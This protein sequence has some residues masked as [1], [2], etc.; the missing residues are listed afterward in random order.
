[1]KLR[2]IDSMFIDLSLKRRR[3]KSGNAPVLRI[4]NPFKNRVSKK[5][6]CTFRFSGI[7]LGQ[8][9]QREWIRLGGPSD[10]FVQRLLF[11][12][13]VRAQVI[14]NLLES[15][16]NVSLYP[17]AA[18]AQ[19]GWRKDYPVPVEYDLSENASLTPPKQFTP[20][21]RYKENPAFTA[22]MRKVEQF[23]DTM[24]DISVKEGEEYLIQYAQDAASAAKQSDNVLDTLACEVVYQVFSRRTRRFFCHSTYVTYL[25]SIIPVLKFELSGVAPKGI[26]GQH[27]MALSLILEAFTVLGLKLSSKTTDLFNGSRTKTKTKPVNLVS[28]ARVA[29]EFRLDL[30][31][32]QYGD[33]ESQAFFLLKALLVFSGRRCACLAEVRVED[34]LRS[35]SFKDIRIQS[36]KG[37][38]R[39]GICSMV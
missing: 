39:N 14:F 2:Q 36:T 13:P 11:S 1:M 27:K 8:I 31:S 28:P 6:F 21:G 12:K 23:P 3:H 19:F 15:S 17:T 38:E 30:T 10:P 16:A 5:A 20:R 4:M 34:L 22:L 32:S 37:S 24:D 29:R 33:L 25:R 18:F 35:K 9:F 7:K 26:H